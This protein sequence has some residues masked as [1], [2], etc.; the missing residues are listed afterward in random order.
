MLS[1][2]QAGR[3]CVTAIVA[4]AAAVTI[5]VPPAS[6]ATGPGGSAYAS[7]RI[8]DPT[9]ALGRAGNVHMVQVGVDVN[10]EGGIAT[11]E[12]R[13]Y[14]CEPGQLLGDC[15]RAALH[16]LV[17]AGPVA[18]RVRVD[19]SAQVTA[20]VAEIRVR[21]GRQLRVFDVAL[22]VSAGNVT[23]RQNCACGFTG[24]DGTNYTQRTF[25]KQWTGNTAAGTIGDFAVV[26]G[27]GTTATSGKYWV[28]SSAPS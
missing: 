16:R 19:G 2:R 4:L 11:G 6:A 27:A 28:R 25:V 3:C 12:I 10:P 26:A 18:V 13:S 5:A 14:D 9:D 22:D 21:D 20:T 23:L 8:D 24:P 7:T 1:R 15:D 17:Q